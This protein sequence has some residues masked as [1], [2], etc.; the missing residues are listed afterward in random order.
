[1]SP[2]PSTGAAPGAD[3]RSLALLTAATVLALFAEKYL[4]YQLL[5]SQPGGGGPAAA[6]LG[7]ASALAG[8][9]LSP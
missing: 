1:M 5:G 7:C 8:A 3:P 2:K 9:A 6:V 4:G